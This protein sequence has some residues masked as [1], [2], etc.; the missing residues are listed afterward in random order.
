MEMLP[1]NQLR[2]LRSENM[3]LFIGQPPELRDVWGQALHG[4]QGGWMFR[5]AGV[6]GGVLQRAFLKVPLNTMRC[7]QPSHEGP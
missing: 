1:P 3:A 7:S 5:L 2:G 6:G 4:E